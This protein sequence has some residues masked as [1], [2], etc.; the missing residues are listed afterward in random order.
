MKLP[1]IKN[2]IQCAGEVRS[3]YFTK[4]NPVMERPVLRSSEDSN[5]YMRKLIL[6]EVINYR[7]MFFAVYLNRLNRVNGWLK[8][9][10]G[11]LDGTVVDVR[12]V[13]KVGLDIGATGIV[14]CHNHPSGNLTPSEADNRITRTVKQAGIIMNINVIDHIILSE[15]NYYSFADNGNIIY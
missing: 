10:E 14:L 13:M 6:P 9:S 3:Y 5:R 11:G 8:V 1:H 15:D 4:P 12:I 2:E 7:E